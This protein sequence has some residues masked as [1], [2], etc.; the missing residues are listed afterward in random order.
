M[1]EVI[2]LLLSLALIIT[3]ILSFNIRSFASDSNYSATYKTPET[4]TVEMMF[5]INNIDVKNSIFTG[6]FS[7]FKD[8]QDIDKDI[9][10]TVKFY[11]D[12]YKCSFSFTYKWLFATYDALF[13]I[14]VY[15]QKETA[16]LNGGG[17][18]LLVYTDVELFGTR[19]IYYNQAMS[20]SKN[21]MAMCMNLS[22]AIYEGD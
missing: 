5:N 2:S 16:I 20:Y 19:D 18:I 10:G 1:R 13:Y 11:G 14:N 6:H 17:G 12:H 4:A 8:I 21:D 7:I 9:S 15:P 22:K 3:N